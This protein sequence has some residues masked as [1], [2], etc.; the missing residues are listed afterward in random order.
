ME[1][2]VVGINRK[3]RVFSIIYVIFLTTLE[4]TF[5]SSFSE[6]EKNRVLVH[7]FWEKRKERNKNNQE[8]CS[9]L[10]S[11]YKGFEGNLGA[12]TLF[13][14]ES[15]NRKKDYGLEL[16]KVFL[17]AKYGFCATRGIS[18]NPN[19]LKLILELIYVVWR[20]SLHLCFVLAY[21]VFIWFF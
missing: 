3:I 15:E 17:K 16:I 19:S 4:R 20:S 21:K 7:F 9:W 8:W 2:L 14:H 5:C 6:R 12:Y 1:T 11:P 13:I 10:F 18:W